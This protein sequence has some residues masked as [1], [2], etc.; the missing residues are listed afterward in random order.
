MIK[1]VPFLLL[2]IC[3]HII[4]IS[5]MR[6]GQNTNTLEISILV[7]NKMT[8]LL[9]GIDYSTRENICTGVI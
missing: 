3:K 7:V 8:I 9:I 2:G 6:K 4:L 5:I 1:D